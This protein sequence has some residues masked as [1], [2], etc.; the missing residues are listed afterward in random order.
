MP[1]W[2]YNQTVFYGD[3]TKQKEIYEKTYEKYLSQQWPHIDLILKE[4]GCSKEELDKEIEEEN[5]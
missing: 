4:F 2:C 5:E 1:N 3:K